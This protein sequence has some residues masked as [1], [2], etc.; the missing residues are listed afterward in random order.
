MSHLKSG[1]GPKA[2]SDKE[3]RER[4]T[5]EQYA[6]TREKATERPFT[7]KYYSHKDTGVYHCVVCNNALFRY[8]LLLIIKMKLLILYSNSFFF[9]F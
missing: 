5:A 4:L 1:E 8:C 3:L 7:G 2:L 9:H 6:V